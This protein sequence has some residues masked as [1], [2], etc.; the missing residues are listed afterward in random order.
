MQALAAG[1]VLVV[2]AELDGPRPAALTATLAPDEKARAA[3]FVFERDRHRFATARGLL[4]QILGDA[5]GIAPARLA[6]RYGTRGKPC[7]VD[8]P[9]APD[10]NVSH[11]GGLAAFALSRAGEVGIDIEQERPMPDLATIAERFFS[12]RESALL[13]Q[14]PDAEKVPAFFRCW[15]RKEAFIK[16]TGEGL[17]RALDAFDVAFAGG[18]PARLL[19]VEGD[20]EAPER[21]RLEALDVPTGF[22]AA[23]AI[24]GRPRRIVLSVV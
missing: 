13:A 24:D 4:R 1:E 8:A 9:G 6:F 21:Y 3:R 14:L 5:A 15:T 22:A 18:E 23:L 17:S 2:L 11:S 12:S 16:L 7:L 10:F 20:P 19:R